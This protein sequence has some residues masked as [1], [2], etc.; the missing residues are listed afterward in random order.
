MVRTA[1]A[2]HFRAPRERPRSGVVILVRI[3][4]LTNEAFALAV[5]FGL[6][7][8]LLLARHHFGG[9]LGCDLL[10]STSNY[11]EPSWTWL[12]PGTTC[13]YTIS[14][15]STVASFTTGPAAWAYVLPVL[16]IGW[17]LSIRR[18]KAAVQCVVL[19][20]DRPLSAPPQGP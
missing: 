15:G 20:D 10:A 19:E 2:N 6:Y 4:S 8:A 12:P 1:P 16:L 17:A 3:R 18:R 7:V 11:G 13:T 9:D 14:D 5:A